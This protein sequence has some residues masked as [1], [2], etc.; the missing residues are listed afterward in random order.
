MQF[1]YINGTYSR[2][3]GAQWNIISL[4][5]DKCYKTADKYTFY[6]SGNNIKDCCGI[7][8]HY[9]DIAEL[10]RNRQDAETT[11]QKRLSV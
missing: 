4:D 11:M 1:Y 2:E 3:H 9:F 5:A 8:Q 10:F 7:T 6:Y